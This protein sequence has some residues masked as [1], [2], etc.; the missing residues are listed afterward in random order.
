M[1]N[2]DISR[3][4]LS[5]SYFVRFLIVT[6]EHVSDAEWAHEFLDSRVIGVYFR[7]FFV[8]YLQSVDGYLSAN[9]S[10][11]ITEV[12][13]VI[14]RCINYQSANVQS[15]RHRMTRSCLSGFFLHPRKYFC[16]S[17]C[18]LQLLLVLRDILC[19]SSSKGMQNH[20]VF[21]SNNVPYVVISIQVHL[22]FIIIFSNQLIMKTGYYSS[23]QSFNLALDRLIH[24]T[25]FDNI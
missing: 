23:Q 20:V 19:W 18:N 7:V 6:F 22:D 4:L 16:W 10:Q 8:L 9:D 5:D 11:E 14:T 12:P 24:L 3:I 1:I 25:S 15:D 13:L 21:I 17:F 2:V